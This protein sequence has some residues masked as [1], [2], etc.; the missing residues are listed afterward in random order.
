MA[1]PMPWIGSR[2]G[3][4]GYWAIG[5]MLEF[6]AKPWDCAADMQFAKDQVPDLNLRNPVFPLKEFSP[7]MGPCP[8]RVGSEIFHQQVCQALQITDHST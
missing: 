6:R 4:C 3:K 1:H 7:S 8:F 5:W 2:H